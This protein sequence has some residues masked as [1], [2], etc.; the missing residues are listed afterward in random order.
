MHC[1][2]PHM[3][4][5]LGTGT[6]SNRTRIHIEFISFQKDQE[7]KIV[8]MNNNDISVEEGLRWLKEGKI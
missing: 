7:T 4:L 3:G 1:T 5:T 2:D 6:K 8:K